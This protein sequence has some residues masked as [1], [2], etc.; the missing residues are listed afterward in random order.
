MD[1]PHLAKHETWILV[2]FS[3]PV[4]YAVAVGHLHRMQ[5]RKRWD[6]EF[7]RNRIMAS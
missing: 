1:L 4:F 5:R 7:Q 3:L 2:E 6:G